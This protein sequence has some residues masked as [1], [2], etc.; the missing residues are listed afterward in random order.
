MTDQPAD[1]PSGSCV[2]CWRR[3]PY[4]PQVCDAC[5]SWLAGLITDLRI[6]H[7][8]LRN[9]PDA[10][11]T[12]GA[13]SWPAL[14]W[15]SGDWRTNRAAGWLTRHGLPVMAWEVPAGPIPAAPNVSR[16]HRVPPGSRPPTSLDGLDLTASARHGSTGP[17]ARGTLGLDDV[18]AGRLP[19]AT[20]LDGWV[21]EWIA[22]RAQGEHQPPATVG[23]LTRWLGD[24]AEWACD[25]YDEVDDFT[26]DLVQYQA[27]MRAV[28]GQSTRPE[29]KDGVACPQCQTRTLIRK[30]TSEYIECTTCQHMMSPAEYHT[31]VTDE[32]R[33]AERQVRL[34]LWA[35]VV[36]LRHAKPAGA[37]PRNAC[38]QS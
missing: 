8:Q 27:Q 28:L 18:Q 24:R 21:R 11:A 14:D 17:H 31:Y 23:A 20:M 15:N 9:E 12:D 26:R 2:L 22:A 38:L 7:E 32:G 1:E 16:I 34:L 10:A 33:E 5:R 29:Y 4:Q 13:A 19:L 35:L 36:T 6:L 25:Q 37:D 3:D 30:V